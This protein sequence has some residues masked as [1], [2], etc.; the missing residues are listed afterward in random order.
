[1]LVQCLKHALLNIALPGWL[2][3]GRSSAI[4]RTSA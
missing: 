4:E 2:G 1:L 3:V